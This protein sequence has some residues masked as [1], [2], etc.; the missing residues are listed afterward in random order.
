M[1]LNES[2]ILEV[3]CITCA[4]HVGEHCTEIGKP[5]RL[6]GFHNERIKYRATLPV[7]PKEPLDATDKALVTYYA[8]VALS[9]A[10]AAKS[11]IMFD[12]KIITS[13]EIQLAFAQ[14]ALT[15][16]KRDGLLGANKNNRHQRRAAVKKI[17]LI[18]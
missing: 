1:K 10:V 8:Y 15:D 3:P 16:L 12:G 2:E 9:N 5:I 7:L 13:Q 17:K 14:Q 4:A 6:L 18:M 11:A